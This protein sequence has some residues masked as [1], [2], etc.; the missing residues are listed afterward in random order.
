MAA[1]RAAA[2]NN[3]GSDAVAVH[4]CQHAIHAAMFLCEF[5]APE[6]Y[7]KYIVD[8]LSRQEG[9]I[10]EG[11]EKGA[12]LVVTRSE[13]EAINRSE[14]VH[15]PRED[16]AQVL[17][18]CRRCLAADECVLPELTAMR[19]VGHRVGKDVQELPALPFLG[20]LDDLAP[21]GCTLLQHD[22]QELDHREESRARLVH[23]R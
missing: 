8:R 12:V 3:H 9:Q 11:H 10:D 17:L 23:V 6:S 16:D 18:F 7:K 4:T 19:H 15:P 13:P 22:C 2:A 1:V 5:A 14:V 21:R 20:R